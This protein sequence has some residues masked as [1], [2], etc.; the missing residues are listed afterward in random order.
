MLLCSTLLISITSL[1]AEPKKRVLLVRPE[2]TARFLQ[3][4]DDSETLSAK[5]KI[6]QDL[7]DLGSFKV[8]IDVESALVSIGGYDLVILPKT[9]CLSA[10]EI[11]SL[12]NFLSVGGGVLA[13]ANVGTRYPDGEMQGFR[14]LQEM[15]G[16]TPQT[17]D[18][19]T[20][21]ALSLNLRF[22]MPGTN[23]APPG[24]YLRMTPYDEVYYLPDCRE[25]SILGYWA[26]SGY[27]DQNSLDIKR[28]VG[29]V[30]RQFADEGRIAWIGS[31]I[32]GIHHDSLNQVVYY[33]LFNNLFHWLCGEGLAAVE[34]W[35]DGKKAAVLIHGDIEHQ[36]VNSVRAIKLFKKLNLNTTFNLLMDV[37]SLH[38]TVISEMAAL[39]G[40]EIAIHSDSH[41]RYSGQPLEL[42]KTR[43]TN[44][45]RIIS[46]YTAPPT[47]FR[48][49]ELA[50]DSNTLKVLDILGFEYMSADSIA[51][52]CYP[53]F[54]R[55]HEDDPNSRKIVVFPKSELD[56]YDLYNG[57][58]V[59]STDD[60]EKM[61]L[62]D[63]ERIY[64]VGGL[65]KFN[66]HTQNIL[67]PNFLKMMESV[68]RK[69]KSREDVWIA[70]SREI[71]R[72]FRQRE[73]IQVSA[74]STNS[75]VQLNVVNKGDTQVND[76]VL[77]II[78][79][80][81]TPANM[82]RPSK[83][84]MNCTYGSIEEMFFLYLPVINA[85]E[86][87]DA[88]LVPGGGLIKSRKKDLILIYSL[89]TL[90]ILGLLFVGWALYYFLSYSKRKDWSVAASKL[91]VEDIDNDTHLESNINIPFLG[92]PVKPRI[93]ESDT[94]PSTQDRGNKKREPVETSSRRERT[95]VN[96]AYVPS[97]TSVESEGIDAS[98]QKVIIEPEASSLKVATP[99][100][101]MNG[102][103]APSIEA[104]APEVDNKELPISSEPP[105]GV[106]LSMRSTA[107]I[108]E[109]DV[110][111]T[112]TEIPPDVESSSSKGPLSIRTTASEP[113]PSEDSSDLDKGLKIRTTVKKKTKSSDWE[114]PTPGDW[115]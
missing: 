66:Y 98:A 22:G 80:A 27:Q 87:F 31:N 12:K 107:Q 46:H 110:G 57:L 20:G 32:D 74:T 10:S 61:F 60:M 36:F 104:S 59:K 18:H 52:R 26:D 4:G 44:T 99:Q 3:V 97:D 40:S 24:Y 33:P 93:E 53:R 111:E 47:G 43:L 51:D 102:L 34:P 17:T 41:D 48:P 67:R 114:D 21:I 38:P 13:V 11:E 76:L 109:R 108:P 9:I 115:L 106:G 85:G 7:L 86:S 64:D 88:V 65:Y 82:L 77:R 35:P 71:S 14:F 16:S 62:S 56:D 1:L 92:K 30:T 55:F 75:T 112:A 100:D 105:A 54:L 68:V 95:S 39:G 78:P 81:L 5:L 25:V 50:F 42:Q 8:D 23:E 70:T 28:Q 49:P 90:V 84:S 29:F 6:W 94:Y 113:L 101:V 96:S 15:L 19:E 103:P 79:P 91:H 63:F 37:G 58:D 73:A 45:S 72:W 2:A 89:R 83:T 69:F